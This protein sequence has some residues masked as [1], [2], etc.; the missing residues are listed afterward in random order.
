MGTR[1]SDATVML[2]YTLLYSVAAALAIVAWLLYHAGAE[3]WLVLAKLFL[4]V[5]LVWLLVVSRTSRARWPLY[6][7][8]TPSMSL[9]EMVRYSRSRRRA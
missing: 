9:T 4:F 8:A 2:A 1:E 3:T 6:Y 5:F 7:R